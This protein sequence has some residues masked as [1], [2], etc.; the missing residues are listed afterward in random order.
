MRYG[1]ESFWGRLMLEPQLLS[2]PSHVMV[3]TSLN[4]LTWEKRKE[5]PSPR[6]GVRL[7]ALRL[8]TGTEQ[9]LSNVGGLTHFVF[10]SRTAMCNYVVRLRGTWSRYS[11]CQAKS[12]GQLPPTQRHLCA[13]EAPGLDQHRHIG[14][15]PVW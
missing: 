12:K 3:D 5:H 8:V 13:L 15:S 6:V 11:N 1:S 10:L 4:F 14:K 2:F 9:V 7:R